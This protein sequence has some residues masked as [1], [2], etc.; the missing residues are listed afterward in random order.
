MEDFVGQDGLWVSF[1]LEEKGWRPTLM[2]RL[3]VMAGS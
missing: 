1:V 3:R 2:F